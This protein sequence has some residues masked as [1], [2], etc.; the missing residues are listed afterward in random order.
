VLVVSSRYGPFDLYFLTFREVD[1]LIS[2]PKARLLSER[3]DDCAVF[4]GLYPMA[5]RIIVLS[6]SASTLAIALV[7]RS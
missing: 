4:N 7:P 6:I 1:E 5:S 2:Y 3:Q